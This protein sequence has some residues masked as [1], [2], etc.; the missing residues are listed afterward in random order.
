MWCGSVAPTLPGGSHGL[1]HEHE[2]IRVLAMSFAAA[3][4]RLEAGRIGN[5]PGIIV[6]RWLALT[7][8]VSREK[9]IK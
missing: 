4:A 5:T 9:Y 3:M 7:R 1:E 2:D 8:D 6:L